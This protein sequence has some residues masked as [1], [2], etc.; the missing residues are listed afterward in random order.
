MANIDKVLTKYSRKII[1]LLKEYIPV[2]QCIFIIYDSGVR[3]ERSNFQKLLKLIEL[4]FTST[5]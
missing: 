5:T 1:E 4:K 2:L 3:R